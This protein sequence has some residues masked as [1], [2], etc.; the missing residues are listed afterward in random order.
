M[1][2]RC[3]LPGPRPGWP[4]DQASIVAVAT[5]FGRGKSASGVPFVTSRTNAR[6]SGAA[7]VSE[8]AGSREAGIE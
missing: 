1:N 2:T 3:A 6:Q 4:P 8:V 5:P 7:A